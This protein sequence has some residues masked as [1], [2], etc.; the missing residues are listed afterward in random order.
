[1][2]ALWRRYVPAALRV[3]ELVATEIGAVTEIEIEL[4]VSS[5]DNPLLL[6]EMLV[7]WLD[8][9]RNLFR[10]F[11]IGSR[12]EPSLAGRETSRETTT[13]DRDGETES[14]PALSLIVDYPGSASD[15]DPE[16]TPGIRSGIPVNLSSHRARRAILRLVATGGIDLLEAVRSSLLPRA[17][18]GQSAA[19]SRG[20]IVPVRISCERGWAEI[21]AASEVAWQISDQPVEAEKLTADRSEHDIMLDL[22]CRRVAGGLIPVPDF[23]DVSHALRVVEQAVTAP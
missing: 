9:C 1:M 6:S 19:A 2:P 11:P 21:R 16:P 12:F 18:A 15:A 10:T 20:G 17:T 3:Q 8:F 5:A 14:R 23:F 13:S 22:F 7:G 4:P